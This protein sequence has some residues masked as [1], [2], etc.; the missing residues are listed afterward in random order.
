MLRRP[1]GGHEAGELEP[2]NLKQAVARAE[3]GNQAGALRGQGGH[4]ENGGSTWVHSGWAVCTGAAAAVSSPLPHCTHPLCRMQAAPQHRLTAT[5]VK[6]AVALA[7]PACSAASSGSAAVCDTIVKSAE[8]SHRPSKQALALFRGLGGP[9]V[10]LPCTGST[11]GGATARAGAKGPAAVVGSW[12]RQG[13]QVR[14]LHAHSMGGS[15]QP[16]SPAAA[17]AALTQHQRRHLGL[18]GG[19]RQAVVGAG[20]GD[21][22]RGQPAQRHH[23]YLALELAGQRAGAARWDPRAVGAGQRDGRGR[24]DCAVVH[25]AAVEPGR[26]AQGRAG[27]GQRL[28]VQQHCG[29]D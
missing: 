23:R 19:H 12:R 16:S 2:A 24:E 22:N 21:G 3:A 28:A 29:L 20:R 25:L 10:Q 1:H 17:A 8:A 6:L 7:L 13:Q 27:A 26:G 11:P 5:S 4:G 15:Q 18:R 14:A 9:S